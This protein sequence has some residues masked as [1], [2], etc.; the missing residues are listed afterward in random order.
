MKGIIEQ[1]EIQGFEGYK[2]AEITFTSGLNLITGRNST[3]K[4]T[5][6]EAI[7]F[8]LY[9]EIPDVDK[10]LLVTRLQGASRNLYLSLKFNS[11]KTW[12][13]VEVKRWGKL[14]LKR[15][16][17]GYQTERLILLVN[18]KEIHVSGEEE[19]R[20]KITELLG[21]TMKRFLNLAYVRQGELTKILKPNKDEMD[22]ILGITTL[23]ELLEQLNL[24]KKELEKYE[25]KDVETE[26]KNISDALL[27]KVKEQ[28]KNLEEQIE[29]LRFEV[30]ELQEKIKRAESPELIN[31]LRNINDRDVFLKKCR[32]EEAIAKALLNQWNVYDI[33][34]LKSLINENEVKVDELK[35]KLE[36]ADE[37]LK[38]IEER[39]ESYKNKAIKV[40]ELLKSVNA[41]SLTMLK[42]LINQKREE[43]NKL[44]EALTSIEEKFKKIEGE[45]NKLEG[46]LLTIEEELKAH[47]KL[48]EENRF[49]CPTC[50]QKITIEALKKIILEKEESEK[51]FKQ[52]IA[53]VLKLYEEEKNNIDKLKSEIAK[54][55]NELETL[56]GVYSLIKDALGELTLEELEE[57][58][59][60]L[61]QQHQEVKQKI[62]KLNT[63]FNEA[64]NKLLNMK[65]TLENVKNL[66]NKIE[67]KLR[68]TQECLTNI[69][70][71]L[72]KL[73]LPFKPEDEELKVKIAEKLPL[74]LNELEDLRYQFKNKN[75]K[76]K[77]LDN[78]LKKLKEEEEELQKKLEILKN[79]LE[80]TIVIEKF[81]EELK[82]GIE[83]IRKVK[84]KDI[85]Y[86]AL[87]IYNSLTDQHV[88][89]AF[90]INP[91]NYLVE[92][93]PIDLDEYIPAVRVG[94][95]HQTLI[96]LSLRLAMLKILG[97]GTLLIL[98]EPTYG[99]DS[100]NIPQLLSHMAE[101]AKKVS[102]VILVTHYGLG[103][104]EAANII[105]VER[106]KDGA[107]QATISI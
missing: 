73:M 79:R 26:F 19:L 104:E 84:L 34:E 83:D 45:K 48:L 63:E 105:K 17:E 58:Y 14:C 24:V 39:K 1:L 4:T 27:P 7:F 76:L 77:A 44:N 98:D 99:V 36:K 75:E 62:E 16:K 43:F 52:K 9:G 41:L 70:F 60:K 97:G 72:N 13:V 87:K 94:G 107:S 12:Q 28:I 74:N 71:L 64:K 35:K 78:E 90:K 51:K 69:A 86:E 2:K 21:L 50:G 85:S 15:G 8:A 102:Q 65:S 68:K 49:N 80:K 5:I 11:P 100:D 93:Q 30:E 56:T 59:L 10:R 81:I 32:E 29:V 89:K 101:A 54:I 92:V 103:E 95:G 42:D 6:L 46:K 3:G 61:E 91:E 31:L 33:I 22:S 38:K 55:D 23:K 67:E 40:K 82:R 53:D 37:E 96:A 18:G 88:Y 25:E 57:A 66:F 47:K 106:G 20:R